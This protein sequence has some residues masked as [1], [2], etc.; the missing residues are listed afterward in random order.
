MQVVIASRIYLPEPSAASFFL[1][2]VATA[3]TE[4]GHEVTVL[5]AKP[6]R[7]FS[8][9]Q[10]GERGEAIKTFPV[11][12][13]KTG[14]VRGYLQYLSF[15]IPLF[16]RL[17][18]TKRPDVVLV[19]PP[20]TTGAVVRLACFLRRIPYVYDAADLWSVA[21]TH[22]TSSSVVLRLLAAAEKWA[23]SGS[24]AI[25][26]ISDGVKQRLLTWGIKKP[27]S[28]TGYGA[29][30]SQFTYSQAPIRTEFV[31]AGTYSVLHGAVILIDAFAEFLRSDEPGVETT[32][33][34]LRFIGS[35]TERDNL[36]ARAAELNIADKVHFVDSVSP[37]ELSDIFAHTAA[38]LA[39]LLPGGGYEFAF[40]TKIYS[41]LASGC[42][43]IFAGPGPTREFLEA[44]QQTVTVGTAVEYAS[45]DIARAMTQIALNPPTPE[46]RAA[47]AAWSR[48][49]VSMT[50]TATRI[51]DVL[52]SVAGEQR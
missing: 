41:S 43:V 30:T 6:P 23:I 42:P 28:V 40:A 24:R 27:I 15:D 48:D 50:E 49:N 26:T 1:G 36:A 32:S 12:R 47:L 4:K 21:A 51:A 20:P 46:E 14:Y 10:A 44:T 38:S 35:G 39:T 22:A 2:S 45:T 18:F 52:E 11:L 34:T 17:L 7:G 13:D 5:T 31:Y 33:Y 16:F 8:M 37:K 9:P 19:E 25:I 29:D 3:L